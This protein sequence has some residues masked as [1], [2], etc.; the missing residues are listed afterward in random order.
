MRIH[1]ITAAAA[2]AMSPVLVSAQT[3]VFE[4]LDLD[5]DGNLTQAELQ[6]E[7]PE[8]DDAHL[9]LMDSD[10]NQMV[11]SGEFINA[12]EAGVVDTVFGVQS[13]VG[14]GGGDSGDDN[15]DDDG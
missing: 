13:D 10:A 3:A 6:A 7:Y 2:L 4:D 14:D 8:F 11:D 9:A 12:L 15:S 5:G 1:M